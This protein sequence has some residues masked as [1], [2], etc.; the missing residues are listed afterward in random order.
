MTAIRSED[1][2]RAAY[3]VKGRVPGVDGKQSG[4]K[5]FPQN[6]NDASKARNFETVAEAA[7]FLTANPSWGIR[8]KPGS[9]IFYNILIDGR[10]R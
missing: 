3:Y 10:T 4:Y 8:M 6:C 9:A 7:T 5:C 1:G 2:T